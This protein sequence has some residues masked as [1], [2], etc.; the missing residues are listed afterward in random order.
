[1]DVDGDVTFNDRRSGRSRVIAA[2]EIG[3]TNGVVR[4]NGLRVTLSPV[5]VDLARIALSDFPLAGTL[6]GRATV[7]GSTNTLLVARNMDLTHLDRGARSR[8]VGRG[9]VRLGDVPYLDVN[10]VARPL[11]LV[12]VIC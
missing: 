7:D 9:A 4:A 11:S 10:V 2:G 6:T 1:M 5:Q 12:T 3:A 8:V